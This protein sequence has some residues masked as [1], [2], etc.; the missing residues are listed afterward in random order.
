MTSL[1]HQS[2]SKATL[3]R[4]GTRQRYGRLWVAA[5]RHGGPGGVRT[6]VCCMAPFVSAA[7]STPD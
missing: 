5:G 1:T 6:L 7:I 4:T 2:N 3:A